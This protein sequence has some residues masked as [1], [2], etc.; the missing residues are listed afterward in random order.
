[1][2]RREYPSIGEIQKRTKREKKT[3]RSSEIEREKG[4]HPFSLA[5]YLFSSDSSDLP[6]L[7]FS[8]AKKFHRRG[9]GEGG[10]R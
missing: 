9:E 2:I 8:N 4:H 6:C 3:K 5:E 1:V 10:R 7:G